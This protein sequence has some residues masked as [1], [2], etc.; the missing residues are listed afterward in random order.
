MKAFNEQ[1]DN[2]ITLNRYSL[3]YAEPCLVAIKESLSELNPW[4]PWATKDYDISAS[5]SF[6]REQITNFDKKSE[7]GFAI[8]NGDNYF[9]GGCGINQIDENNHKANLG[10]WVRS[11]MSGKGIATKAVSKLVKW[12]FENT[13]I[14]RLEIVIAEGNENSRKVAEKVGAKNEGLQAKRLCLNGVYYNA[15]MFSIIRYPSKQ[16]K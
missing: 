5:E 3:D 7:Y 2:L 9:L 8:M 14:E 4:L 6:V 13:D 10:Y 12:T 16:T 1:A 11:S 15:H